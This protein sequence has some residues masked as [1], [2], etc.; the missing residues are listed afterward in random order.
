MERPTLEDQI[1][2]SKM[3]DEECVYALM[4][5]GFWQRLDFWIFCHCE[6][7]WNLIHWNWFNIYND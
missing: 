6:F 4:P 1:S 7:L 5:H 3:T 2:I